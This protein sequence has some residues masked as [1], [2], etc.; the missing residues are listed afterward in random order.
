MASDPQHLGLHRL[1]GFFWVARTG[2]YARAARAFPYPITQPAVHQQV[3]KLED[4]LAVTLFERVAK[5]RMALTPAGQRLFDF[6]RPFFE[7]LPSVIRSVRGG[8]F[9]GTLRVTSSSLL[10]RRLIPAWIQ[11]LHAA[12]PSIDIH[13]EESGEDAVALLRQGAVDL[14]IDHMYEVPDDIASMRVAALKPFVVLPQQHAQ[15]AGDP[16]DFSALSDLPF[17]AYSQPRAREL[18]YMALGQHDVSPRSTLSGSSA[19]TILGFI[20]AGLGWSILPWLSDDEP[21]TD[22]VQSRTF[23]SSNTELE[24][25]A[26]WR[27]DCPDNPLLD[28]ML[29]AAPKP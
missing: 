15:A 10:L 27:K 3:K 22:G 23:P 26:A 9:G 17:V 19:E 8:E 12:Y 5:D 25:V 20:A 14:V 29:E 7:S 2:G 24:I 1:E 13:L 28:A 6:V 18:Q 16:V 21:A 4:E 11:R